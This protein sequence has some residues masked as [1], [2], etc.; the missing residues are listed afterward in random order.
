MSHDQEIESTYIE[1][2]HELEEQEA[3]YKGIGFYYNY[4][5]TWKAL[6]SR[7]IITFMI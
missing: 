6:Y 4:N 3:L 1:S 2:I 5:V 7:T